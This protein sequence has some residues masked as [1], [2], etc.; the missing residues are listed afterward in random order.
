[1][2]QDAEAGVDA[3]RLKIDRVGR[4]G[5]RFDG[6]TSGWSAGCRRPVHGSLIEG[7]VE[8][9]LLVQID[10]AC[11]AA[12][13]G[14]SSPVKTSSSLSPLI[15]WPARKSSRRS[16][17]WTAPVGRESLRTQYLDA[18]GSLA[19]SPGRLREKR[20]GGNK[21]GCRIRREGHRRSGLKSSRSSKAAVPRGCIGPGARRRQARA[22]GRR[23]TAAKS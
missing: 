23:A 16:T 3:L 8:L 21:G 9:G 20:A 11:D 1:M 2:F 5:V 6:Q 15:A 4:L 17:G 7:E 10:Q 13:A 14:N 22:E 19:F 12:P 18:G